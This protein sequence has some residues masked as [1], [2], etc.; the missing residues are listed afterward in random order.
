MSSAKMISGEEIKPY[1]LR[2]SLFR[3]F[4][5]VTSTPDDY[6][7]DSFD[8]IAVSMYTAGNLGSGDDATWL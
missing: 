5:A 4:V 2:R 3:S 8:A 6:L 7:L 1:D